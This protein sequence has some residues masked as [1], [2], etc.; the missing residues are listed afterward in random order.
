MARAGYSVLGV[1]RSP[2]AVAAAARSGEG[3][4]FQVLDMR[5]VERLDGSS[6]AS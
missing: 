6:T 4:T 3:A 2:E 5:E 1:D